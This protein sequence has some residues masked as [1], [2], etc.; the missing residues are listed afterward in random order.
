MKSIRD[1]TDVEL[2]KQI[3]DARADLDQ[4]EYGTGD[5]NAAEAELAVAE[6]EKQRRKSEEKEGEITEELEF[7][8]E[9]LHYIRKI[10]EFQSAIPKGFLDSDSPD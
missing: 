3:E 10:M 9:E 2:N 8:R 7:I 1:F 4:S 6:R 5:Y